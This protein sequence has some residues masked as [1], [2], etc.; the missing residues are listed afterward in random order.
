MTFEIEHTL[1]NPR[2]RMFNF[3]LKKNSTKKL[4]ATVF[5]PRQDVFI[6]I[7]IY[8]LSIFIEM[9][10]R[11]KNTYEL[12]V[13]LQMASMVNKLEERPRLVL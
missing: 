13:K 5:S 12:T 9:I 1:K 3:I 2:Q 4:C 10:I 11:L 7:F 8:I 6:L